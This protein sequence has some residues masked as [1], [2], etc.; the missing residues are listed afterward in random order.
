LHP[1]NNSA[2]NSG[3]K[4]FFEIWEGR[5]LQISSAIDLAL[6]D[7]DLGQHIDTAR[8]GAAGHSAGGYTVLALAGAIP[9]MKNI[10][11]HCATVNDA[12][13]CSAEKREPGSREQEAAAFPKLTDARIKA[14][15]AMAPVGA[16]F[17]AAS[18]S[19][20]HIPVRVYVAEKDEVLLNPYHGEFI[21]KNLPSAE[22]ISVRNAG[23]YSF[24][25]PFPKPLLPLVGPAGEDP[26]GFDRKQFHTKLDA[27]I[28]AFFDDALKH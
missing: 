1:K 15:V 28:T 26:P 10:Y 7:K 9:D 3:T 27:E 17:N 24:L 25:E 12:P 20:I 6:E 13:F 18:M 5:P 4:H 22:Y 21:H 23:H 16:I 8:I 19:S 2:D 14:I 11:T